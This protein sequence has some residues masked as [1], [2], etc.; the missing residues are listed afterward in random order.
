MGGTGGTDFSTQPRNRAIRVLD[1]S[2]PL[3][4][5]VWEHS[6]APTSALRSWANH[7]WQL[8]DAQIHHQSVIRSRTQASH[9]VNPVD[10]RENTEDKNQKTGRP[11]TEDKSEVIGDLS[12][13]LFRPLLLMHL[14]CFT[15]GSIRCLS[16]PVVAVNAIP[17]WQCCWALP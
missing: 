13:L 8:Q 10:I 15:L 9:W 17:R 14:A 16:C 5:H 4:A 7:S 2:T 12:N 3:P 1:L 6:G 11:K